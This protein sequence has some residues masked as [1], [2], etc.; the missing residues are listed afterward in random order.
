VE[1]RREFVA[2]LR[3]RDAEAAC[4]LMKSHLESVH[5]LLK[6]PLPGT[7]A[8]TAPRRAQTRNMRASATTKT[9][10]VRT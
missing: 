5:R 10:R 1:K 6:E 7:R 8:R 9:S 2:A 4:K 3:A